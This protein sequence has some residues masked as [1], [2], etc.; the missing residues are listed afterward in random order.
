MYQ[1]LWGQLL[2]EA[3]LKAVYTPCNVIQHSNV[4]SIWVSFRIIV[5]EW[6]GVKSIKASCELTVKTRSLFSPLFQ[7][8]NFPCFFGKRL[9]PAA[10]V[11]KACLVNWSS[12]NLTHWGGAGKRIDRPHWGCFRIWDT[13]R[14]NDHP[15]CG[16][17]LCPHH[18]HCYHHLCHHP[19]PR[20]G[21]TI[22]H[23]E[24]NSCWGK[25]LSNIWRRRIFSPK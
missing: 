2:L 8:Q 23:N 15:H 24:H 20:F 13:I 22:P 5:N 11:S 19:P 9:W 21:Q 7:V 1:L 14:W 10:Q 16:V 4:C 12:V 3:A 6:A 18:Y 17:R 25:V